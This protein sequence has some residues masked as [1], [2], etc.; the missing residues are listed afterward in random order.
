MDIQYTFEETISDSD[1]YQVSNATETNDSRIQT[2]VPLVVNTQGWIK[3]LGGDLLR[4]IEELVEATDIFEMEL[5]ANAKLRQRSEPTATR[6]HT[7]QPILKSLLTAY[8]TAADHRALSIL[9]YF[10]C[11]FPPHG[12]QAD[13]WTTHLPL[14]A[15]PPW[16]VDC[17]GGI[18]RIILVGAG[19]EDVVP[20]ELD[21]A[22]NCGIVAL[23]CDE[24]PIG[25]Y[26]ALNPED[27]TNSLP[28]SQGL[29]VPSPSTSYCVGLG[30]IR[31]V[32]TAN[33]ILHVLTPLPSSMVSRCR[34]LVKGELELPVWGMLDFR[35][36]NGVAGNKW[37]NVPYLQMGG[38]GIGAIGAGRKRVRKN[39]MRRGQIP[40]LP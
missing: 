9:S 29:S 21:R 39:L 28:Y 1:L 8:Y 6:I 37:G 16:E 5:P 17:P 38:G 26:S 19:Y 34:V 30:L 4:K 10:H 7:L 18:D 24:D 20:Q 40:V 25:G 33:H 15:R 13:K 14:C 23:V 32:D 11:L 12:S 2:F 35:D 36:A 3:G 22:I 27:S 31:G